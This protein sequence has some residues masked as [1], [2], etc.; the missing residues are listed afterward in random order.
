[1]DR[2]SFT[3]YGDFREVAGVLLYG[4][5]TAY[6]VAGDS[7]RPTRVYRHEDHRPNVPLPDSLFAPPG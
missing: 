5:R 2:G 6:E 4:S 3:R 1:M 7:V